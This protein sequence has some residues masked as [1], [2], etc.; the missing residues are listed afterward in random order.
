[1][2]E[3]QEVPPRCPAELERLSD[4]F[5]DAPEEES[6]VKHGQEGQDLVEGST[7]CFSKEQGRDGQA[8]ADKTWHAQSEDEASRGKFE[9][10]QKEHGILCRVT[11]AKDTI[12]SVHIYF[13]DITFTKK[14]FLNSSCNSFLS[15]DYA[16]TSFE[17]IE[18]IVG[19]NYAFIARTD[20]S[21]NVLQLQVVLREGMSVCYNIGRRLLTC[22]DLNRN[23]VQVRLSRFC[24]HTHAVQ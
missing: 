16:A 14:S 24:M 12:C 23:L 3:C 13:I 20:A 8:V 15:Q 21:L 1:M 11:L 9:S 2:D 6:V 10:L 5:R 18:D 7:E 4:G 19:E 17:P 22:V